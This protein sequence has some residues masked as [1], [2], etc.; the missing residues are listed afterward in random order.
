MK[1]IVSLVLCFSLIYTLFGI[2][3]S[4][5]YDTSGASNG[6][7]YKNYD[8]SSSVKRRTS[9][10]SMKKFCKTRL[11]NYSDWMNN[12]TEFTLECPKKNISN[13]KLIMYLT[14]ISNLLKGKI[15]KQYAVCNIVFDYSASKYK[16]L[17]DFS[18]KLFA[19]KDALNYQWSSWGGYNRMGFSLGSS[20]SGKYYHLQVSLF[21]N[22]SGNDG[23][24]MAP[25]SENDVIEYHNKLMSIYKNAKDYAGHD[26]AKLVYY[27]CWWLD[28]N[29]KY[30]FV[31]D[32]SP[33]NA[34]A[35]GYTVC[36][37]YANALKDLCNLSGIPSLVPTN[38]NL[39]HAWNQI[40][41]DGEWFTVDLCSVVSSISGNYYYKYL[42]KDPDASS[43]NEK[44]ENLIKKQ[45]VSPTPFFIDYKNYII[46]KKVNISG[47]L[48]GIK[49]ADIK[50]VSSNKDVIGVGGNGTLNPKK[51]G[52]STLTVSVV[53]NGISY[54][55]KKNVSSI[56]PD[57]PKASFYSGK[58]ILKAVYKKVDGASGFEVEFKH[59]GKTYS[60]KYYV[61]SNSVKFIDKL[62]K[63]K[64]TIKMRAFCKSNGK[65]G[66]S[67]WTKTKTLKVK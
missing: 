58:S 44:V 38:D 51:C 55:F 6:L 17:S 30:K 21:V 13:E 10:S 24:I 52:K 63:G 19:L 22:G 8:Y 18:D 11:E 26:K 33:I 56:V 46:N 41:L 14:D 47:F 40:Y 42:F 32:N 49:N 4:A 37:G 45:L 39:N 48:G 3:A 9:I 15:G 2:S 34:F 31:F 23:F 65:I 12:N 53:Q 36:G 61:K 5:D 54:K 29:I 43:D 35:D 57:T 64:Y 20:W 28:N 27:F 66:Y 67:L 60:K 1:K 16:S 50:V 62:Q 25:E 59:G 7:T